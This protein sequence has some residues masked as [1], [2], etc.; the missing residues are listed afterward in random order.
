MSRSNEEYPAR[1]ALI[2]EAMTEQGGGD[3][4]T[5]L[6]KP[7]PDQDQSGDQ[8]STVMIGA[9]SQEKLGPAG[10]LGIAI[11]A[12]IRQGKH[13]RAQAIQGLV[14]YLRE[15][16]GTPQEGIVDTT[17]IAERCNISEQDVQIA[18]GT[19]TDDGTLISHD[20]FRLS[21]SP[22]FDQ[23]SGGM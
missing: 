22:E 5:T 14:E 10:L 13:N 20:D 4:L 17:K 15:V 3:V 1:D 18:V 11:E 9:R 2:G 23:P 16:E 6:E 8:M 21:V 7:L 12:L 19:L